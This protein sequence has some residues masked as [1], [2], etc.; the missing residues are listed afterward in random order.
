MK[1]LVFTQDMAIFIIGLNRVDIDDEIITQTTAGKEYVPARIYATDFIHLIYDCANDVHD[2]R[3]DGE[4][5][6]YRRVFEIDKKTK[7]ISYDV[8]M[9]DFD[10]KPF[11]THD[12]LLTDGE[13]VVWPEIDRHGNYRI[14]GLVEFENDDAAELWAESVAQ[15]YADIVLGD[16]V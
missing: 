7:T 1:Y 9:L 16:N 11:T 15:D 6:K 13:L 5:R 4:D 10:G 14:P 2:K 12:V 8:T 3:G